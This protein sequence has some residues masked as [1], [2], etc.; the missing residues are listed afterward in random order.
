MYPEIIEFHKRWFFSV[1][2]QKRNTAESNSPSFEYMETRALTT[3]TCSA[4]PNLIVIPCT[5]SP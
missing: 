5:A 2:R 3:E 4:R 1:K